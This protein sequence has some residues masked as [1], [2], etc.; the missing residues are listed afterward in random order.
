MLLPL[1]ALFQIWQNEWIWWIRINNTSSS[2]KF[3]WPSLPIGDFAKWKEKEG[4][5]HNVCP[6]EHFGWLLVLALALM[7]N[8]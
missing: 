1:L 5:T 6:G 2:P 8:A 3:P 4:N 7:M